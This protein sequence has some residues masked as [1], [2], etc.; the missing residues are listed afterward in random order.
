MKKAAPQAKAVVKSKPP[1]PAEQAAEPSVEPPSEAA[2]EL[3]ALSDAAALAQANAQFQNVPA[4]V[5]VMTGREAEA[6]GIGT[7]RDLAQAFSNVT[8]FDSGGNRMT[9]FSVRG[10]HELGYQSSPGVTPSMSYYVDDVPAL[11][12]LARASLFSNAAQLS[13]LKGPQ[14]TLFGSSL[15][16]G[17]ID[18]HSAEP[19]S[20]PTGYVT[21]SAGNYSAYQAGAGFSTPLGSDAVFLTAD[22][23]GQKRDGFFDNVALGEPYGDKEAYA[24]K[25]KLTIVP[26]SRT[27]VD[28]ILQHERFDDQSDPFLPFSQLS[29]NDVSYNDPGRERIGQDL[30]A[31]R[32]RTRLDGFDLMSVTAHRHSTWDFKNDGD[33]TA[34]PADPFNPFSRLV[35][36]SQEDVESTTQE[37]RLKSNDR[38]SRLQW[39]AGAFAAHTK[40]EFDGGTMIYPD[41]ESPYMPLRHATTTSNDA[42][43]FGEV[44]YDLG[45]GFTIVP[46]LRYEW[47]GRKGENEHSAPYITSASDEFDAVLPSLALL[48]APIEGLTTYAKY[49]R[50]F[51]PGGYIADRALTS[52][53]EFEFDKETSDNYEIG[54]KSQPLGGM[55]TLNGSLFYSRFNDYQV[56]NQ[57]SPSEFGVNNA[58]DVES[59]GG[60][61]DANLRLTPEFR[62][63][64]GLGVTHAKFD[65]FSNAYA[66]FSGNKVTFIPAF[67]ANYGFEYRAGWGGYV[68]V[69]GRTLGDYYLDEANLGKQDGATIVN[70]TLGYTYGNFDIALFG[71]NIFD[72]RYV[73]NTYDFAGTGG[74]GA[75]GLLGDPATYGVRTKVSF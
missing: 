8:G 2:A 52:I 58:Q 37:F 18:I 46:G 30:Q 55:L 22:L 69:D 11:T 39:S 60:E 54:F 75:Y 61:L 74:V 34:S 12:S 19:Y 48:Y 64:G 62:L 51:K 7:A 16:A 13:V 24:G 4:G 6:R 44:R 35:G 43:I 57:F 26:T 45:A 71:R 9:T 70:A 42:A 65:R 3:A 14:G 29:S 23:I 67:T 32:V 41:I 10:V 56:V 68:I 38:D 63:F 73:I 33:Q 36:Y 53:E 27:V 15:P 5:S 40:M 49:A 20:K 21:A 72:E 66:D 17:V 50:G 31:L 25:A 59:Y 47:A 28:L 1:Q